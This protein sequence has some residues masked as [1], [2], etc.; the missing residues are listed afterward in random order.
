V[1]RQARLTLVINFEPV[2]AEI[3]IDREMWEKMLL[4]LLANALKYT[5]HGAIAV[6]LTEQDGQIQLS[7]ADTGIG[8]SASL[9]EELRQRLLHKEDCDYGLVLVN[10]LAELHGGVLSIRSLPGEGSTFCITIP[11]EKNICRQIRLS[12]ERGL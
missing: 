5:L 10:K 12:Q 1:I 8:M 7:V 9:L 2:T 11:T 3:Y 6:R 4:T